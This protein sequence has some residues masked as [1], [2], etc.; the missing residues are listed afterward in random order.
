[1]TGI[2]GF[3]L[4]TLYVSLVGGLLLVVKAIFR[5][6]LTPRWQY[7]V[8]SVLA[9]RILIPVQMTWKYV[10]LPLP[11][12]VE[13]ARILADHALPEVLFVWLYR[14]YLMGVAVFL[15]GYLFSYFRLGRLLKRGEAPSAELT[16]QISAVAE[17]YDLNPCKAVIIPGLTSPMVCGIIHPVLAVPADA[18]L[19][20]HVILHELL[21]VKY[22]DALQN[23]FWSICRALH[24]CNP[25]VHYFVNQIGNDMESLC[26]QR[27]LERLEGEARRNYGLSL[28]AMSN[29]RYPRAPGTTSISNGGKNITRRIEAI[30]RF[31][32][33]PKG[34]GES[35]VEVLEL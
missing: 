28:L 7:G 33:Y 34:L 23:V 30:V 15:A 19:D 13:T 16:Q 20:D 21:H 6:K 5:D 32:K 25:L 11:L 17:R 4:Q 29:D 14:L 27:V 35:L 8:W 18:P 10:L 1:M 3:L 9:L 22:H 31:K 2:W 26:D 12:W 24:W